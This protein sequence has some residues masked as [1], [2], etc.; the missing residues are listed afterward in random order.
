MKYLLSFLFLGLCFLCAG[1]ES[2][3]N[4][5][6][7][8]LSDEQAERGLITDLQNQE[9]NPVKFKLI[10]PSLN[11]YHLILAPLNNACPIPID[12]LKPHSA[13]SQI[14]YNH[15]LANRAEPDDP[16][17]ADQWALDKINARAAWELSQGGKNYNND[18]IVVAVI[19]NGFDIDHEDLADN[20]WVNKEEVPDDGIDNDGNGYIDDINGANV[21]TE[22]G[23]HVIRDHG[24]KVCGVLGAKGNNNLGISGIAW[25][26]KMMLI[27]GQ[28]SPFSEANVI[29]AY[30]YAK[31][32]RKKYN[33]SDGAEGAFIVATNSSWGLDFQWVDSFPLWCEVYDDLGAE[34][35][36]SIAATSNSSIDIDVL[37]DMPG[38]CSSDYLVMVTNID[39]SNTVLGGIGAQHVDIAAPGFELMTTSPGDIYR[40]FGG[41]SAACPQ[42]S[43]AVAL[44]Y[45][46]PCNLF[47]DQE[48]KDNPGAVALKIKSNL[49]EHAFSIS[50]MEGN[51]TSGGMLDLY[52]HLEQLNLSGHNFSSDYSICDWGPNPTQGLVQFEYFFPYGINHLLSVF[53]SSGKRISR[54]EINGSN[55]SSNLVSLDLSHYP[56]GLY[57]VRLE[58]DNFKT[59]FKITK[60]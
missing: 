47:T 2:K 60:F 44:S 23:T 49:L 40:E 50:D 24:T 25:D 33:D 48:I 35:I 17:L 46:M 38:T 14:N 20:I 53:D 54:M 58:D 18:D 11:I 36:L 37:G 9:L 55:R 21:S 10:Y 39:Q 12:L 5:F 42:V 56:S 52:A 30:S 28:D 7:L 31:T 32:A 43:G 29:E 13:I 51:S 4:E 45:S 8:Q 59:A 27:S 15:L 22:N 16:F 57:F 19:D 34:G 6:I 26:V 41:T 3:L 1:Q